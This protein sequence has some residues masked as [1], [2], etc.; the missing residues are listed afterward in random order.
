MALGATMFA[1]TD[2]NGVEINGIVWATC[3]VDI[4]GSFT[5]NPEDAGRFYQWNRIVSWP[6]TGSVTGWPYSNAA[7]EEW[8]ENNDPSPAGWRIPTHEEIQKLLETEKVS[9]VWTTENG[10]DGRKFT[11]NINGNSIF[12]PAVG[13]RLSYGGTL[14]SSGKA[15][16]YWSSTKYTEQ[17]AYEFSFSEPTDGGGEVVI[18]SI[19]RSF[20]RTI[21]CVL[22]VPNAVDEISADKAL[23]TGYYSITGMKLDK[24]PQNGLYIVKYDNGKTEKINKK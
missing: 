18:G 4:S 12:L 16:R 5:E 15:G 3:N 21:R 20:G 14:N 7:G 6:A 8:E 10:T 13:S 2:N 17:Q 11:D 22:D 23:V 9:S 24:E 19:D 1:Q